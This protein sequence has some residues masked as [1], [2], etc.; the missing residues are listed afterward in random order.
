MIFKFINWLL[1]RD[2]D[3]YSKKVVLDTDGFLLDSFK[4]KKHVTVDDL[5]T[6]I[7]NLEFELE[8]EKEKRKELERNY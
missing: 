7:D 8:Y 3:L 5:L 2:I 4:G 1:N 6:I